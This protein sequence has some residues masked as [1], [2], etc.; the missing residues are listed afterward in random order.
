M[1]ENKESFDKR[2]PMSSLVT[3][4]CICILLCISELTCS[5]HLHLI[6][7]HWHVQIAHV[8]LPSPLDF[9]L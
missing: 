1:H 9:L 7:S 2:D 3:N 6:L 5:Q 8:V 4:W